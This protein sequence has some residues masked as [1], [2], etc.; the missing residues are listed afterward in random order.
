MIEIARWPHRGAVWWGL[1]EDVTER[2]G[3]TKMSPQLV[4]ADPPYGNILPKK[5]DVAEVGRWVKVVA[6]FERF[7]HPPPIYWW[8]GIGKPTNRPFF[9][10]IL[11]LEDP[12]SNRSQYRMR[13]LITW[14]KKRGYG[15]PRDYL[16]VR[17]ECALLT[18]RGEAPKV[19]HIPLLEKR[20]GYA[21]YNPKFP[22]KSEFLRR[23]NVWD[24]TE[25]LKG[26]LHDAHKAPV[27]VRV[28]IQA[29]TDPHDLVVDLY[30]GSGETSLQAWKLGRRFIAVEKDEATARK[31]AQ[32]L[33]GEMKGAT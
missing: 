14:R 28:P 18:Y 22:A 27:V 26:K 4:I 33:E 19:F 32:R 12:I 2:L 5:W 29:H 15:K 31:I 25:I 7:A 10:F 30:S 1:A 11:K 16:F 8:G 20:R 13:D 24:E 3:G 17:E 9:E 21:G 6:S 23:T